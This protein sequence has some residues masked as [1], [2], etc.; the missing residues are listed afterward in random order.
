MNFQLASLFFLLFAYQ[1]KHFLA[2]YPL[3]GQWMLRK[4]QE[5]WGFILP[6]TAHAG[7][8]AIMTFSIVRT[9]TWRPGG[10]GFCFAM[11]GLD[12]VVH[13]VMDR[14]KASPNFLGRH[15]PLTHSEFTQMKFVIATA[16]A[17]KAPE[18]ADFAKRRLRSNTFFW[19][20]LGLDQMVH[21]LTHYTII[22]LTVLRW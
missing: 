19:W 2:D 6:L 11:A 8:H 14:I 4:F 20:S 12:F 15:R 18:R 22:L 7:V 16:D 9:F 21:H 13:F 10:W 3:Q 1:L 5:D 17:D